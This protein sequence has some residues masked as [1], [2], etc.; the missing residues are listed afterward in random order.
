[1]YIDVENEF[2]HLNNLQE[3]FI[4]LIFALVVLKCIWC[5]CVCAAEFVGTVQFRT[6][7]CALY[8]RISIYLYMHLNDASF[9]V[10]R[11]FNTEFIRNKIE[12]KTRLHFYMRPT[13]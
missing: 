9:V 10:F 7:A 2:K 11:M 8:T 1:M 12:T 4:Y 5:V 6:A 13:R 3:N